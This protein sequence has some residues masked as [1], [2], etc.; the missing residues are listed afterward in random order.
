MLKINLNSLT[1]STDNFGSFKFCRSCHADHFGPI[2]SEKIFVNI[3]RKIA[4]IDN[5]CQVIMKAHAG[6]FARLCV[7]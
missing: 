7:K 4:T 6:L 2:V 3:N 5:N 1:A